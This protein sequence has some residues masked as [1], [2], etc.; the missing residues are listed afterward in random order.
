MT[1]CITYSHSDLL[2]DSDAHCKLKSFDGKDNGREPI[3][4]SGDGSCLFNAVSVALY[5]HEAHSMELRTQTTIQL[6]LHDKE[7]EQT[8]PCLKDVLIHK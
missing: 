1:E 6:I 2:V 4:M 7:H 8:Y 5:G 3:Q